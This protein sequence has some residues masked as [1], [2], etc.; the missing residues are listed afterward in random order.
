MVFFKVRVHTTTIISLADNHN[1]QGGF[2]MI[3]LNEK[4]KALDLS[5]IKVKIM[6]EECW[7]FQQLELAEKFYKHFLM[8]H[9]LEPTKS[10]VPHKY[11]DTFWHYHM[12]DTRKYMTDCTTLF[13]HFLH[14]FPYLGMRGDED[15]NRAKQLF[16]ETNQLF[17]KYFN[18]GLETLATAF[19]DNNSL[20]GCSSCTMDCGVDID[21]ATNMGLFLDR[22]SFSRNNYL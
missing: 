13:G 8:L 6:K 11:I 22:P 14:H 17:K 16:T 21:P 18:E 9:A 5:P 12:L 3:N 15:K 4:F 2:C 20:G 7:D 19:R 10:I 1:H